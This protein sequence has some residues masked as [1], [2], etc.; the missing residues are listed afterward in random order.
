MGPGGHAVGG[1]SP[2]V[3]RGIISNRKVVEGRSTGASEVL[4]PY[5]MAVPYN[6]D[7]FLEDARALQRGR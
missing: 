7:R 6:E 2:E 4:H 5:C 1:I 3:A